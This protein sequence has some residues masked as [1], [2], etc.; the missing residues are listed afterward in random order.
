MEHDFLLIDDLRVSHRAR[1]HV[2]A[3]PHEIA[4][5]FTDKIGQTRCEHILVFPLVGLLLD[6][7]EKLRVDEQQPVDLSGR[8]R[9]LISH[10]TI[11][12]SS[13]FLNAEPLRRADSLFQS[14]GSGRAAVIEYARGV[15]HASRFQRVRSICVN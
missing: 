9:V 11:I 12:R 6:G 2:K 4:L 15:L 14:S 8:Q 10:W 7:A 13:N 3:Y 5:V 1:L